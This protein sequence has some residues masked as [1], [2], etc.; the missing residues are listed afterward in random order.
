MKING[1]NYPVEVI[2]HKGKKHMLIVDKRKKV[3]HGYA[4]ITDKFFPQ[5]TTQDNLD[6]NYSNCIKWQHMNRETKRLV[7]FVFLQMGFKEPL[8]YF[9][10]TYT[11]G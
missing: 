6:V 9:N 2:T 8:D 7:C 4:A 3:K 10:R 5:T 1:T 11:K